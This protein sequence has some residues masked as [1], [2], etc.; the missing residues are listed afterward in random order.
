MVFHCFCLFFIQFHSTFIVLGSLLNVE[1]PN[2]LWIILLKM[3]MKYISW[4]GKPSLYSWK[5]KKRKKKP[6]QIH[7]FLTIT[8]LVRKINA[9]S[10]T[11]KHPNPTGFTKKSSL[12]VIQSPTWVINVFSPSCNSGIQASFNLCTSSSTYGF[13]VAELGLLKMSMP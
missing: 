8:M 6:E 3:H 9:S 7:K 2:Y 10:H 1:D 4:N 13:V 11:E 5:K 12:I